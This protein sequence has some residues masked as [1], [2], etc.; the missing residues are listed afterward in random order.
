MRLKKVVNKA[1]IGTKVLKDEG[2]VSFSI[3]SLQAIQKKKNNKAQQQG[4][5]KHAIYTKVKYSDAL[6]ADFTQEKSKWNGHKR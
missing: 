4:T 3:K 5:V 6:T 1:R 2:L